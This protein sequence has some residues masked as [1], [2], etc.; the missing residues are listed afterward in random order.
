MDKT[1]WEVFQIQ[2]Y[3]LRDKNSGKRINMK[4]QK[5]CKLGQTAVR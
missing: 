1:H 4:L 3:I 2:I 5:L